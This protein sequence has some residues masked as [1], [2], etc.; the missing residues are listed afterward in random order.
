MVTGESEIVAGGASVYATVAY[1]SM[2]I[3][4]WTNTYPSDGYSTPAGVAVDRSGNVF[5]TGSSQRRAETQDYATVE[6]SSV[7]VPSWTN[8][9]DG[10]FESADYSTGIAV[11]PEGNV[12]LTGHSARL[13]AT[14]D[15]VTIKYRPLLPIPLTIQTV[16]DQLV[17]TWTNSAFGLQSAV[18]ISG[19]FVDI[20]GATSPH[21]NLVSG[22]EGFFRLIAQ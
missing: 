18:T 5:V 15:F 4:L 20:P 12:F 22:T 19:G 21:T 10:G 1:S 3:P 13:D 14:M 2:G 8:R 6:Y 16:E 7:G 11:D 17:L 9:S